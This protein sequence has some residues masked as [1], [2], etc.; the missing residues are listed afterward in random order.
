[1][2]GTRHRDILLGVMAMRDSKIGSV[3][4]LHFK[5]K[6]RGVQHYLGAT[7]S[8][9]K[10]LKC[11][12]DGNGNGLIRAVLKLGGWVVLANVI[13]SND[14]FALEKKLK[15]QHNHKRKCPICAGLITYDSS[16]KGQEDLMEH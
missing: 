12:Y 3:Y 13:N 4:V 7:T 6:Y 10:R 16:V 15:K 1:M 11:H 5:D 2:I 8:L 9:R 14:V